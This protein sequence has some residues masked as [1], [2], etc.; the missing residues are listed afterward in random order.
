MPKNKQEKNNLIK[1]F[2]DLYLLEKEARDIYNGFLKEL[3]DGAA[4][5]IIISIH[6]DEV[7]HMQIAKEIIS[8]IE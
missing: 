2:T 4:K 1:Q 6:D 5:K 8:F 7:R 3:K